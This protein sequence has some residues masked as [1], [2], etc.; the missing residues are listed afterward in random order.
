MT[1]AQDDRFAPGAAA[2]GA[3]PTPVT[4]DPGNG[5]FNI[6]YSSGTTGT[7]VHRPLPIHELA[8]I[9]TVDPLGLRAA[10]VTGPLAAA[11]YS[12]TTLVCFQ[13][14]LGPA[15]HRGAMRTFDARC[16]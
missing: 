5:V 4:V 12:N 7:Q 13:S 11:V 9:W 2:D 15:A 14:D 10:K 8:A 3:K 1:A 6:I 16:F